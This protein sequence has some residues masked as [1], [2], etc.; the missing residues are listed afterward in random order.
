MSVKKQLRN[1]T[2]RWRRV[3]SP[4]W[5]TSLRGGFILFLVVFCLLQCASIALL[6]RLVAHTQDNIIVVH[7]LAERQAL[8]DKSRIELLTASDDINRAGIYFMQDKQ[9]G[10]VNSWQALA[11]SAALSLTHAQDYF[12][13][14][15]K[16]AGDSD[17]NAPLQQNFALLFDGLNEQLKG[18]RSDNLDA[19]FM[20]PI[21]AFQEQ[22]NTAFY[23]ILNQDNADV[24]HFNQSILHSLTV[25]RN[26]SLGISGLLAALLALAYIVLSY[27][28][29]M[30]LNRALHHMAQIATGNIAE[31]L[32]FSRWQSREMQ[33]LNKGLGQMQQG[34]QHI[35]G[36]INDISSLVMCGA[37]E[38]AD[39][40]QRFSQSS[41]QQLQVFATIGQ[42]LNGVALE[43][44]NGARFAGTATQQMSDAEALT[45]QCGTMVAEVGEKMH[46]IVAESEKIA[47][48]VVF[49][50]GISMQTKLLSLNAAIESAHAGAFG[51]TFSVVA[52][53]MALLSKKS[54]GS[55][56]DIDTLV[57][58]THQHI[59]SGF[60]RVK[61]LDVFYH[62]IIQ[63][64]RDVALLLSELRQNATFQSE[65][66]NSVV[67]EIAEL[68]KQIQ[69]SSR[70]TLVCA[71]AS[72]SLIDHSQRLR[73]SVSKFILA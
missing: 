42:K 23:Q 68:N 10:S 8:M 32:P 62:D 34:L 5:A 39:H 30:P 69:G 47:G 43:A 27:A 49:L 2:Q 51:R 65:Q 29:V 24:E 35:V 70:L 56:A 28:V 53:E 15:Q 46:E 55:T 26:L 73:Q 66:V 41:Q 40:N 7:A 1:L 17:K 45:R 18:L 14:Y 20:V 50:E 38:I 58:S 37:G 63:A 72:Q 19:F 13:A 44:D 12:A 48:I 54:G 6:T 52:Q 67:A 33:W 36:E 3:S 11:D 16:S 22:F 71:E 9:T 4:E 59:D 21:Q 57:N 60:S 25:N 31:F 61:A 64:V